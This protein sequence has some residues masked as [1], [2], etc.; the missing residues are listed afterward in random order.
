MKIVRKDVRSKKAKKVGLDEFATKNG[1]A[2]EITR[3]DTGYSCSFIPFAEIKAG[4][5]LI[6]VNGYGDTELA[7][8]KDFIQNV[9][10]Q[11]IVLDAYDKKKRREIQVPELFYDM[12][13]I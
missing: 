6:T 3:G 8:I 9:S 11:V 4:S 12:E 13:V 7:A 5:I 2:L 10:G 1:L